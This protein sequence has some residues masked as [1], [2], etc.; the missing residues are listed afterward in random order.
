MQVFRNTGLLLFALVFTLASVTTVYGAE[1]DK[2]KDPRPKQS[3]SSAAGK[4]SSSFVR[5][6]ECLDPGSASAELD[7][8]NVRARLFNNG[9]LFYQ[10]GDLYEVPKGSGQKAVFAS[11]IWIGGYVGNELRMAAATYDNFEFRPGPIF[12]DGTAPTNCAPYDK[13]WKVSKADIEEYEATGTATADMQSWPFEL[14]AP[15][16][17]GDGNPNNYNLA[18]GDRPQVLGDQTIWWVM[19]DV[20]APHKETET[21]PIGLEAQVTAFAFNQAGALGNTT[22]YKY[23]LTYHGDQP[24][25]DTY[26]GLWSDPD[27]GD[28]G[29]DYVGSDTLL[30]LG[31]V[32]NGDN[33]DGG[34]TGYGNV[35]PALGYDF[36]QGPLVEAPGE[37]WID[38]DG[39]VHENAK[40]LGMQRFIYYNN[41]NEAPD[42]NPFV[43]SDYYGYL[44]GFWKDGVPVTFGGTG[45]GF[46]ET[47][48]K[49][50]YPAMPPAFWSEENIDGAGT[51]IS[52]GDRRFIMSAGPF[53]MN[54]GDV[55]EIVFGIVWAQAE[56]DASNPRL[57]SLAKLK[58]DDLLAQQVF[59]INF[60]LPAPPDAPRVTA[61]PVDQGVL[62]T[63]DYPP[64]SNNFLGRYS[65]VNPLISD[66]DDV[67]YD[68]E[69]FILYQFNS[70]SDARGEIVAVFDKENGVTRILKEQDG[71]VTLDVPGTDS[72]LQYSYQFSNLTNYQEYYFGVQAYA[73]NEFSSPRAYRSPIRRVTVVPS[74]IGPRDGGTQLVAGA[75]GASPDTVIVDQVG[76]GS[77][78]V[79][80]VDPAQVTGAT[81]QVV[82]KDVKVTD[83]EGHEVTLTVYDIINQT[84]NQKVF[85]GEDYARRTGAAPPQGTGLFVIDGL[86]FDIVGPEKKM[87]GIVQITPAGTQRR[88]DFALSDPNLPPRFFITAQ[89]VGAPADIIPRTDW[90]FSQGL[91]GLGGI[92]PTD[93]EIRFVENPEENGQIA[94]NYSDP[95]IRMEGWLE[96]PDGVIE[97]GQA[98]SSTGEDSLFIVTDDLVVR[99]GPQGRLP[100]QVWELYADGTERQVHVT[101][102][103]DNGDNYWGLNPA[104]GTIA[105]GDADPTFGN[106]LAG[107]ERIYATSVP[108]DEEAILNDQEAVSAALDENWP[109]LYTIGRS[110]IVPFEDQ[111]IAQPPGTIIRYRTTKP[112]LAGDTFTF[113]TANLAPS[114]GVDSVATASIDDITIVPNPYKG[115]SA[116]E[117][118]RIVDVV[119][120]TNLPERATI[121]IFTLNGTLIRTLEKSGPDTYINWDLQTQDRLPIASGMYLVHVEAKRAD[122]SVIGE[123]IIKFGVVKKLIQLN[124]L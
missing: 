102:L 104:F 20:S 89:G 50:M 74:K 106:A 41:V 11:S 86:S 85:D 97:V 7:V 114:R 4:T 83:S 32:Y 73:Y 19:N 31:Y 15:V 69:G 88:L 3:N 78:N 18:G 53:T 61:T 26:I 93:V 22:F 99:G 21:P 91:P 76:Q 5:A 35:P 118:S 8:N 58:Q 10:G 38:P 117:V 40:R 68:F 29:D 54:P 98:T 37:T 65:A 25:T 36:F 79:T 82:F 122:G 108:Y 28:A 63:W 121:R 47:P 30:G 55:Q 124:E 96:D 27:L 105:G 107:W 103:D 14:G 90:L 49:Y 60:E 110:I 12:P 100:F 51:A 111:Y 48:A 87:D 71:L 42:G 113:D 24:L 17:D 16:V 52:P 80:V 81:Y 6:G 43:A 57:A 13:L 109:D 2:D 84:T 112:N 116:Y 95:Y 44:T 75:L 123:K 66:V 56:P 34:S 46:S 115:A 67:T 62:L 64:T 120:I 9:N 39:T 72:G 119:R 33:N 77:I 1:P 101:I 94:F 59:D 92:A 70:P 45:R 23:K